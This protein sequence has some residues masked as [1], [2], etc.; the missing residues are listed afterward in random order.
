[1]TPLASQLES[2][3]FFKGEPVSRRELSHMLAVS[4]HDIETAAEELREHLEREKRGIRVMKNGNDYQLATAPEMSG[5]IEA[6]IKEDLQKELGKAGLETLSIVLY[7]GPITR[8]RIDYIRGVN[9]SFSVRALSI[10]GLIDRAENPH[11]QRSFVYT[12]SLQLLSYLGVADVSQ[13]PE[14]T[15]LREEIANF[16]A[17]TKDNDKE[18]AQENPET[19][20]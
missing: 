6:L 3:L 17:H 2:V 8:A 19:T 14:Y 13:L 1:M 18:H 4:E 5:K 10:R 20:V 15:Q 11:D 12:P 16:E 9:S 7:Y